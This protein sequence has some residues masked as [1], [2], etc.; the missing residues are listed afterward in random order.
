MASDDEDIPDSGAVFTFGKSRFLDDKFWIRDDA[1]IHLACGDEHSAVV[2]ENGKL[3]TFGSNGWGQ[4]GHG[5]TVPLSCPK[6]VKRLKPEKVRLVAAGRNHTIVSTESGKLFSF[7]CGSDGQ[8]GHGGCENSYAPKAIESLPDQLYKMLACGSD[9]TAVITS[10][11]QLYTWGS[12]SEGQTGHG[13]EDCEVPMEVQLRGKAVA[14]ACGYYHMAVATE[15]G[16]LYTCGENESGK[17]GLDDSRLKDTS[18]LQKVLINEHVMS[19]ACGG[20]H[21]AAITSSGKLFTFGLGDHG[22]LGHGSS[23]LECPTPKRVTCLGNIKVRQ[24]TCG[25]SHTAVITKHG[26]L[27]TCG[28]GRHGKLGMGE[29]SFSNLFK[30]E[31][32][33]RFDGFTVQKI[34]CGGCHTL[35]TAFK[36][37]NIKEGTDSEAEAEKYNLATS[38]SLTKSLQDVVDGPGGYRGGLAATFPAGGVARNKRRQKNIESLGNSLGESLPPISKSNLPPLP[39]VLPA[40]K[41]ESSKEEE[42]VPVNPLDMSTLPKISLESQ[43]S[44]EQRDESS[45]EKK[46]NKTR[47]QPKDAESSSGISESE[48]EEDEEDPQEKKKADQ[49]PIHKEDVIKRDDESEESLTQDESGNE[50]SNSQKEVSRNPL[51]ALVARTHYKKDE[52]NEEEESKDD[53]ETEDDDSTS[54]GQE[55]AKKMAAG[56]ETDVEDEEDEEAQEEESDEE[57]DKSDSKEQKDTDIK[58]VAAMKKESEDETEE[59]EEEVESG[60]EDNLLM[61]DVEKE[62]PKGNV[63]A[64]E[65]KKQRAKQ[66]QTKDRSMEKDDDVKSR[67]RM[68]KKRKDKDS[69][70]GKAEEEEANEHD[71]ADREKRD[72]EGHGNKH[73]NK[74]HGLS[75]PE[76]AKSKEKKSGICA[77]L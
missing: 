54:E 10:H 6:L 27:Y 3:Y 72:N 42:K 76:P 75:K 33:W 63:P 17:L 35:V 37:T 70:K 21:T 69:G 67:K 29:E 5:N 40:L 26:N 44:E 58:E 24:V 39:R 4:L 62:E 2:T 71:Q 41:N 12:S 51:V 28:D 19:V 49:T 38:V 32:V 20:N 46:S 1:V 16:A 45:A 14:V 25:E 11:G 47:K 66:Q 77:I 73:D 22:Q 59:E 53:E 7:G 9:F 65:T 23:C 13:S 56:K 64:D 68:D 18:C 43:G 15:D 50:E 8:L 48:E 60:E 52:Y 74:D 34:A 55:P 31:K 36:P 30:L 57:D 61:N